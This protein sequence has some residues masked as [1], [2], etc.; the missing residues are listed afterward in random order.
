M[1]PPF[2]CNGRSAQANQRKGEG[3]GEILNQIPQRAEKSIIIRLRPALSGDEANHVDGA[4]STSPDGRWHIVW[5][6]KKDF[7]AYFESDTTYEVQV[8]NAAANKVVETF[9]RN[10]FE[11]STESS[12][13]GF[14]LLNLLPTVLRW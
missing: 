7:H 9:S 6:V 1:R 11:N 13:T 3:R 14:A 12:V 5:V 8:W 10:E 2:G 4:D